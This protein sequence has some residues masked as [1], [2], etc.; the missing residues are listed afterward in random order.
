MN[1]DEVENVQ[2]C[3]MIEKPVNSL[4]EEWLKLL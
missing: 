2:P 3:L 1:F 4:P